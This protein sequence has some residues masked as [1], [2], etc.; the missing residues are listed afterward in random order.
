MPDSKVPCQYLNTIHSQ[1]SVSYQAVSEISWWLFLSFSKTSRNWAQSGE[2]YCPSTC[3]PAT[4]G[5][6]FRRK[7]ASLLILRSLLSSPVHRWH[8]VGEPL[9][10]LD[11]PS[12]TDTSPK[13]AWTRKKWSRAQCHLPAGPFHQSCCIYRSTSGGSRTVSTWHR[14]RTPHRS[15]W[16]MDACTAQTGQLYIPP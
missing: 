1:T 9:E 8:L 11:T 2:Y 3:R 10:C 15:S 12:P 13:Q 7:S 16:Q 4:A 5:A 6:P 14:E